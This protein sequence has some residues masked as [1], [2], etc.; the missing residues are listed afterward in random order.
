MTMN[1]EHVNS[2]HNHENIACHCK[3][4][5]SATWS[6]SKLCLRHK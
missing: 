6:I 3:L 2:V 1:E 4:H 5:K